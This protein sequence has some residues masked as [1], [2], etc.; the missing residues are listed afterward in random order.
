M[1]LPPVEPVVLLAREVELLSNL[2]S[3]KG[4]PATC[5][6]FPANLDVL[7]EEYVSRFLSR[8]PQIQRDSVETV[9]RCSE[10]G[11][12]HDLTCVP[13]AG[14]WRSHFSCA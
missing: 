8:Q 1:D 13:L 12:D 3:E 9:D 7:G 2:L 11:Q 4:T 5:P 6:A 14:P 10:A